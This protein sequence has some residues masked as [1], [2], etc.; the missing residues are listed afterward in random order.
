MTRLV[1]PHGTVVNVHGVEAIRLTRQGWTPAPESSHGE[2]TQET[3]VA[4]EEDV[5]E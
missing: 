2:V 3:E 4:D 1:G 5:G